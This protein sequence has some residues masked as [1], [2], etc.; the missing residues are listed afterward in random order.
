MSD[1]ATTIFALQRNWDMVS[2]A[3]AGVDDAALA[4]MPNDQSNSIAWLVWHMTRVVDRFIHGRFLD[5]GQVMD[6]WR[7]AREVRHGRR[8]GRVRHR[9]EC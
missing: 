2:T 5:T 7:L 1:T 4:R 9:L 8:P 3:V 6:R